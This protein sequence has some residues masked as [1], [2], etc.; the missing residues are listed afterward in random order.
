VLA[1]AFSIAYDSQGA[2]GQLHRHRRLRQRVDLEIASLH[3]GLELDAARHLGQ[4][5]RH[6]QKDERMSRRLQL[7]LGDFLFVFS[8]FRQHERSLSVAFS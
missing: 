5:F 1:S 6:R 7:F 4:C 8:E 2:T 3:H